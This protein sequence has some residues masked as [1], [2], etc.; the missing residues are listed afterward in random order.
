MGV[1]DNRDLRVRYGNWIINATDVFRIFDGVV[2][3]ILKLVTDQ[4]AASPDEIKAIVLVGGF[5]KSEYL[6]ERLQAHMG[7]NFKDKVLRPDDAWTAVVKG[8]VLRGLTDVVP[9]SAHRITILNRKARKNLGFEIS[10]P[11]NINVHSSIA[12][13]RRWSSYDG[14]DIVDVMQWFIRKVRAS[15]CPEYPHSL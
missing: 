8:A 11:Y 2:L 15:L 1:R 7:E 14:G 9:E 4:Q 13:K 6:R 12:G 10:V 3:Q 5:G